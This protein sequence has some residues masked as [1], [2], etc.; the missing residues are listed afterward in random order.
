MKLFFVRQ[1]SR[2]RSSAK[3]SSHA[4]VLWG[5]GCR[6][7]YEADFPCQRTHTHPLVSHFFD[8]AHNFVL[9]S[10][11]PLPPA[12]SFDKQQQ[13]QQPRTGTMKVALPF[14]LLG[15][16]RAAIQCGNIVCFHNSP[17]VAGEADPADLE[18]SPAVSNP[19]VHCQCTQF[20]T[21]VD[22]SIPVENCDDG[23]HRCL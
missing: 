10:H 14:L 18:F 1:H 2:L 16:T 11:H 7:Q 5:W 4:K 15:A 21:G 17:C 23:E 20:F 3:T 8:A 19:G 9:L 6:N 22:C 13:Q 12:T